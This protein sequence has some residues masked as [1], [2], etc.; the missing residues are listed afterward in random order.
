MK[1]N[2]VKYLYFFQKNVFKNQKTFLKIKKR[3]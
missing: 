1:K 2:G 3:F